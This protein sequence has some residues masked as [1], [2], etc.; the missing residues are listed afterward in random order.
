MNKM[1]FSAMCIAGGVAVGL[2]LAGPAPSSPAVAETAIK[3]EVVAEYWGG[4]W[5]GMMYRVRIPDGPE[6]IVLW[7]KSNSISC[8]WEAK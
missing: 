1:I 3:A 5:V 2:G 6:C 8:N 4:Y 7:Q